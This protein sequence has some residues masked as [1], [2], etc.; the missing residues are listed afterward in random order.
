[1]APGVQWC[2]RLKPVV[3]MLVIDAAYAVMNIMIKKV[4]DEGTNRLVLIIFRQFIAALVL[5]PIAHFRERYRLHCWFLVC[6]S[7]EKC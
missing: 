1:M 5:A 6:C 3:V 2:S 4:I 7:D